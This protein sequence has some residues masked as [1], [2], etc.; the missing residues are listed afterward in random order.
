MNLATLALMLLA[1]FMAYVRLA[2]TNPADWHSDLGQRPTA[3][4][5]PS[6]DA[7]TTLPNGAYTDLHLSPDQAQ[8]TLAKLDVLALGTPR[9]RRL[10]GSAASGRITWQT[11][12]LIWGFPDYTTAQIT[13]D[14]LT[15]FARQRFGSQDMGVN[16]ARLRDWLAKL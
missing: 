3:L 5:K 16:T 8:T 9:T 4:V 15:I 6:P 11:R 10:A 12:S 14:G 2:P 7:V 1:G 13:A